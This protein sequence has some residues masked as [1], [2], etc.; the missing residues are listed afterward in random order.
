M[1]ATA[2]YREQEAERQQMP[3]KEFLKKRDS[4]HDEKRFP[5]QL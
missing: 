2:A 3:L 4:G 5:E 1:N